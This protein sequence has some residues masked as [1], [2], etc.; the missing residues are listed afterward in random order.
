VV[1][2]VAY[3]VAFYNKQ[4]K[5]FLLHVWGSY[6]GSGGLQLGIDYMTTSGLCDR[7]V[8]SLTVAQSHTTLP[9]PDLSLF[10]LHAEEVQPHSVTVGNG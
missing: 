5:Y 4:H 2:C 6:F 10:I 9:A 3:L 7:R 1:V 8:K